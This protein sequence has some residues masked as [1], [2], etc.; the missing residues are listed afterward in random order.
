MRRVS[1]ILAL[2][3]AAS[4]SVK[5][6]F[7]ASVSSVSLL[8]TNGEKTMYCL[9]GEFNFFSRGI[10]SSGAGAMICKDIKTDALSFPLYS[11][12]ALTLGDGTVRPLAEAR[13]GWSFAS[14][15]TIK[16]STPYLLRE[17]PREYYLCGLYDE[18]RAGV[19]AGGDD[20][21]TVRLMLGYGYSGY[22]VGVNT[23]S[24]AR[25]LRKGMA[26]HLSVCVSIGF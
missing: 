19:Y 8:F 24:G 1:I 14:R 25:C 20:R 17:Q 10:I 18:I 23:E 12:V 11:Y 3:C 7:N 15:E 6:Q 21:R 26:P 5:A 22:G 2:L 4:I 9:G 16:P 13:I